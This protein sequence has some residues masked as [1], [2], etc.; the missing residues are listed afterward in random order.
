MEPYSDIQTAILTKLLKSNGLKFSQAFPKEENIDSDLYNYHLQYLIKRG[1]VT[2]DN[3]LYK[4]TDQGHYAVQFFDSQGNYYPQFRLSVLIFVVNKNHQV[5]L[6]KRIRHPCMGDIGVP[7]GKIKPGET[8]PQA[9]SRKLTEETG[10][11]CNFKFI[12][13]LLSIR[14]NSSSQLI[15]DPIFNIALGV[16]PTG[17]LQQETTYGLNFWS[18]FDTAIEYEKDNLA[19]SKIHINIYKHLKSKKKIP[20]FSYEEILVLKGY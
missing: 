11:T 15:E 18:D 13:T 4:L 19:C 14:Y 20:K 16:N 5:L 17:E 7:S 3:D 10:L 6:Q 1:L 12:G 2:K 8:T 9:A